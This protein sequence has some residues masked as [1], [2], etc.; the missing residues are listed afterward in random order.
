MIQYFKKKFEKSEKRK[1]IEK[2]KI[3]HKN[4]K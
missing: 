3:T 2:R 1:S 4:K